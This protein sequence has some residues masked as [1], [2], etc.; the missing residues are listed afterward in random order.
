MGKVYRVLDEQVHSGKRLISI[1]RHGHLKCCVVM[2]A[3]E[4]N[5]VHNPESGLYGIHISRDNGGGN[6]DDIMLPDLFEYQS[7]ALA[8]LKFMQT[9]QVEPDSLRTL[10]AAKTKTNT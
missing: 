5:L 4:Y 10:L 9:F 2:F 6:H 1:D 3:I 8:L 7:E